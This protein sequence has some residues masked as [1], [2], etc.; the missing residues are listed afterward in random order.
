MTVEIASFHDEARKDAMDVINAY[1]E[2]WPYTRSIDESLFAHW[3]HLNDHYQPHNMLLAYDRGKPVA[4]LHGEIIGSKRA[5]CLLLA[6]NPGMVPA[7]E[8]LLARFEDYARAAGAE[9]I[10][11]PNNDAQPF[12]SGYVLGQEPFHPHFAVESTEV[13]VRAGYR[14]S[15]PAVIM[16]RNAGL[17]KQVCFPDGYAFTITP[18]QEHE[19]QGISISV[20]AQV[21]RV[22]QCD[23]RVYP[24]LRSPEGLV[25][26]QIGPLETKELHRN[27]GIARAMVLESLRLLHGLGAEDVLIA[28]GLN[29]YAALH[30]YEK[31]GFKRRY[32]INEWSKHL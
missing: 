25:V 22:A 15:H 17:T 12:Y 30:C 32:N 18:R 7:A 2:G 31:L 16:Q 6:L 3:K 29:N 20:M 28:T 10:T 26:G 1:L 23:A 24:H 14:I 13:F 9:S 27:K 5:G 4:F 8:A 11:G 21:L 19:A